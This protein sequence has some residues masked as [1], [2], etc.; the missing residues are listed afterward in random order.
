M[1]GEGAAAVRGALLRGGGGGECPGAPSP[2]TAAIAAAATPQVPRPGETPTPCPARSTSARSACWERKAYP[3]PCRRRCCCCCCCT[4][5][6]TLSPPHTRAASA[7]GSARVGSKSVA[8]GPLYGQAHP[9]PR[10]RRA[11]AG[12]AHWAP[13]QGAEG[14]QG[15]QAIAGLCRGQGGGGEVP[16]KVPHIFTICGGPRHPPTPPY[17]SLPRR[18]PPRSYSSGSSSCCCSCHACLR[19]TALP[20]AGHKQPPCQH[21]ADFMQQALLQQGPQR[22]YGAHPHPQRLCQQGGEARTE[23]G[24]NQVMR[25]CR[26]SAERVGE[27]DKKGDKEAG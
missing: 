12:A 4:C 10:Q 22:G 18:Q 11:Q 3:Y 16:H 14:G 27:S 13:Q 26:E 23:Q 8:R 6:H 7:S 17:G 1:R 24:V 20:A 2:N 9:P 5:T 25:V 15:S 21:Q 19:L